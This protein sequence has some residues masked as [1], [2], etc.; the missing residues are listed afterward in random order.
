MSA[1]RRL[2]VVHAHPDDETLWTGGTIARYAAAGV[3]VT[4]VTCTLGEQGEVITDELRGLAADGAD[5][6]GGYRVAELHAACALL[7][8]TDQQFL[9]GIGR[10][11]DSGMVAQPGARASAPADLHPRAFTAGAFDE[12]VGALVGV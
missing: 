4:V 6:L 8:V 7:G 10:W 12:Q 9:G 11:R 5:Q 1:P 3:A 2:L